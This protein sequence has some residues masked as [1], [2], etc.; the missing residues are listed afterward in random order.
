MEGASS[1]RRKHDLKMTSP[2]GFFLED[3]FLEN[4][5]KDQVFLCSLLHLSMSYYFFPVLFIV[6]C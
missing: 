1:R 3:I 6:S 4:L 5:Y 2:I